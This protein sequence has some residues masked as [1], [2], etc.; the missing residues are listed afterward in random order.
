MGVL[1]VICPQCTADTAV[2]IFGD[3]CHVHQKFGHML[4]FV[5]I[6]NFRS[7]EKVLLSDLQGVLALVGRNGAGKTNILRAIEWAAKTAVSTQPQAV[8]VFQFLVRDALSN[9]KLSFNTANGCFI[10]T[11]AQVSLTPDSGRAHF[12]VGLNE[13]LSEVQTGGLVPIVSRFAEKVIIHARNQELAIGANTPVLKSLLAILP[14]EDSLHGL[15]KDAT[16][17]LEGVRYYPLEKLDTSSRFI[18]GA[19]YQLW[20]DALSASSQISGES[21]AMRLIELKL[22]R[23]ED[24]DEI[25]ELVGPNGLNIIAKMSVESVHI[26]MDAQEDAAEEKAVLPPDFYLVSFWPTGFD[27]KKKGQMPFGFDDLSYGTKRLLTIVT[28]MVFDQST[29]LLIEQPEDGIHIGLL[30]KLTPMLRAYSEKM[31]FVLASHSRDVLDRFKPRELRL[32]SLNAGKT[33]LRALTEDEVKVAERFIE[34]DGPLSD[35]IE[36]LGDE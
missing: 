18:Q 7:C 14:K 25:A 2:I 34:E 4:R 6:A 15:L 11:V 23:P 13:S 1:W 17:Y 32:V 31:Q 30:N 10:Y 35:F 5:E 16:S 8:D 26:P 20:S 24:F 33:S 22:N 19:D 21:V 27:D 3:T 9:V 36:T 28:A 12:S 29:V